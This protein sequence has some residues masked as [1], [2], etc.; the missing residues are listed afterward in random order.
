[1]EKEPHACKK[2]I[3]YFRATVGKLHTRKEQEF[4]HTSM[5]FVL[6]NTSCASK[7]FQSK[8]NP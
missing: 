1:M 4:C 7:Y 2:T 8:L 5:H 3:E 6:E